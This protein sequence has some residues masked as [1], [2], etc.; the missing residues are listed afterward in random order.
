TATATAALPRAPTSMPYLTLSPS[1][2]DRDVVFLRCRLPGPFLRPPGLPSDHARR[3][4][5]FRLRQQR[6][7]HHFRCIRD[8]VGGPGNEIL[9][10][11]READAH[12]PGHGEVE[13][14]D[15]ALHPFLPGGLDDGADGLG[16]DREL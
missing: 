13:G 12:V 5:Q 7:A 16:Y 9:L 8:H 14:C 3:R 15:S 10:G 1:K 6:R 2:F 11:K 4:R